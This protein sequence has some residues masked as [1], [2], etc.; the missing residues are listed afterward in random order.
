VT[1]R[2]VGRAAFS[3]VVVLS[4]VMLFT[5]ASGV[6]GGIAVSDKLVHFLLF[7]A[8]AVTGR[9]ARMPPVP[10]AVS[11]VGYAV[12]SEVL[13]WALPIDRDADVRDAIADVLGVATGMVAVAVATRWRRI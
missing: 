3:G 1:D 12:L 11:L 7:T 2:R 9:L 5:P 8:L 4:L 10:L 13:Q 6:P